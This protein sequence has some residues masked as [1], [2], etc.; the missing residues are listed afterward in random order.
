MRID[1][2]VVA[3]V[4]LILVGGSVAVAQ[5]TQPATRPSSPPLPAD[6]MLNQMLRPPAASG[7]AKPLQPVTGPPAADSTSGAAAVA[8]DAPK[9]SVLREGTFLVD[10]TG[11]I[12]RTADGQQ[13]EI[14]FDA[15]ARAMKDPPVIILPNL[16]LMAMEQ[17]SKGSS[18]TLR[19]RITG[20]VTEY[21][22][23]N[24]ILLEKVF[25]LPEVT[26]QF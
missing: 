13:W 24:Y 16:W 26:Q 11:T 18:R 2:I 7:G 12:N 4:G 3:V 5:T 14:V 8:P 1:A 10:R 22:G 17:A 23:R 19:F 21:N 15:D 9:L 20:M 25:V 6:Q